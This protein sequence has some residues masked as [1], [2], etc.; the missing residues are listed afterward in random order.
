MPMEKGFIISQFGLHSCTIL[1]PSL[2][3]N[4][5]AHDRRSWI[6]IGG[7]IGRVIKIDKQS[8]QADQAKF[9][10]VCE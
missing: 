6:C 7:K 5:R 3:L 10:R 2:G 1:G 8:W 9:M 4:I